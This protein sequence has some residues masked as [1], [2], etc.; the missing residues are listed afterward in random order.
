MIVITALFAIASAAAPL[1]VQPNGSR[2]TA[3]DL[4]RVAPPFARLPPDRVLGYAPKPGVTRV[5][6]VGEQVQWLKE[7]AVPNEL[8]GPL[9]VEWK[10]S[11]PDSALFQNAMASELSAESSVSV[12]EVSQFPIP[13]GKIVFPLAS[14]RP[15]LSGMPAVWPGY[16]EYAPGQKM[17]IW[18]KVDVGVP[19]ERVIAID[20][21]AVGTAITA[22][23]VRAE[24]VVDAPAKNDFATHSEVVVGRAARQRIAAGSSIRLSQLEKRNDVIKGS[25]VRLRVRSGAAVIAVEATTLGPAV[26]GDRVA[27]RLNDSGRTLYAVLSNPAEAILDLP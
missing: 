4:A 14:L 23:M 20:D 5:I 21:I 11:K 18:A 17:D 12:L 15:A 10:L 16:I 7:T 6:S 22:G 2:F 27:V 3:A 19:S 9:C 8:A 1:C 13:S 26:A 25:V 24:S